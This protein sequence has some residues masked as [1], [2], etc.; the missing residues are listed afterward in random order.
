MNFYIEEQ[1]QVSLP[2]ASTGCHQPERF[3]NKKEIKHH[4]QQS[5]LE[6]Y[7]CKKC[8]SRKVIYTEYS[9]TTDKGSKV[10]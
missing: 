8:L 3:V 4:R 1:S 10:F 6:S 2:L 5:F 7:C 9:M